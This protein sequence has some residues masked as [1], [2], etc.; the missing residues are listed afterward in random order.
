MG[1]GQEIIIREGNFRVGG[2]F[3][4]YEE[5]SR[6][7]MFWVSEVELEGKDNSKARL[8]EDLSVTTFRDLYQLNWV[9]FCS[10][11]DIFKEC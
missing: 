11:N 7:L 3:Q 10:K 4:F 9:E 1:G 2:P 5:D 8:C 6:V